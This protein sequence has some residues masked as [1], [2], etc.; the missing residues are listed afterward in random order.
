MSKEL[1]GALIVA[2]VVGGAVLLASPNIN[3]NVPS[4]LGAFPGGDIVQPV[5]FRDTVTLSSETTLGY[6]GTGSY[7]V[8]ALG[9]G[10]SSTSTVTS[11][12]TVSG[13]AQGDSA[14][15]SWTPQSATGTWFYQEIVNSV[16]AG[17]GAAVLTLSNV[18]LAPTTAIVTGT[19]KV[20][21]FD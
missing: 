7:T 13:M 9:P 4:N 6:C 2:V 21:Y 15:V 10:G 8:P 1:V 11:S 16:E 3:V 17:S 20:C 14:I 19:V 18:N 5:N 12:V